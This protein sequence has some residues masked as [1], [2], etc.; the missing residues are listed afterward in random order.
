MGPSRRAVRATRPRSRPRGHA[1]GGTRGDRGRRA[2]RSRRGLTRRAGPSFLRPSAQQVLDEPGREHLR[3]APRLV[4]RPV[5]SESIPGRATI[6]RSRGFPETWWTPPV[7]LPRSGPSDSA[8]SARSSSPSR[9]SPPVRGAPPYA[10]AARPPPALPATDRARYPTR[11]PAAGPANRPSRTSPP[12]ASRPS[13]HHTRTRCRP[14]RR[15]IAFP[16][17]RSTP[18]HPL[19]AGARPASSGPGPR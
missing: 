18:A 11:G 19:P 12:A 8:D 14:S 5:P 7:R 1:P 2:A 9:A 4:P 13:P 15:G 16:G 10:N 3:P 17:C 6:P